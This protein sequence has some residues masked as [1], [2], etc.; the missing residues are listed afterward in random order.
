MRKLTALVALAFIAF[1]SLPAGGQTAGLSISTPYPAVQ[2]EPGDTAGFALAVDAPAGEVVSLETGSLPEGWVATFRG[3]GLVVNSVTADPDA[4]PELRLDVIVPVGAEEGSYP[5]AVVATGNSGSSRL[6]LTVNIKGGTA[7]LVTLEPEF[8]GLQ[9]PSNA[10]FTFNVTVRNDSPSEV[11]LE[12]VGEGPVGWEVDARP[13]GSQQA[14]TVTV[15]AGSTGRVSLTAN[16]PVDIEAGDYEMRLRVRGGGV[17]EEVTLVVRIEGSFAI[18]LTTADDRLNADVTA[19]SPSELPLVIFNTGSAVLRNV[20]ITAT[21]PREWDVTFSPEGIAEIPPGEFATVTATITPSSQ[22]IAGDYR[23]TFRTSV[24]QAEDSVE[25]RATVSPSA[26]W[27]LVGV[28]V[29][30]LTLGALAWVFRRF[31]RR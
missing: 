9:G 4:P 15:A 24:D 31:G 26:V 28:G 5:V 16:P 27:G 12:L 1:I 3:A 6:D 10:T 2:V 25:I 17:D 8:P 21:P 22:A 18:E 23:M 30:A 7:G 20:T 14:S 11:Q 29:I 19:G 13:A